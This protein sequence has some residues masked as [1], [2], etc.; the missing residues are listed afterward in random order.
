[1]INK[2][3]EKALNEQFNKELFASHLYLSMSSYFLDKDLDGFANYFRIQ[4]DEEK[5]HAMKFF[6]YIH[7][8]DGKIEMQDVKAPETNF[9]SIQQVF[10]VTLE[11]EQFVTKCIF[12]LVEQSL[13]EKDYATHTFLQWF[14]TEQVE[15]EAQVK[16]ILQKIKMIK[17]NT[18]ALYLLN[19]ELGKR[20]LGEGA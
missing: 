15:E 1:M 4:S 7:E 17:D 5:M 3:I 9:E 20:T 12:D 18:S 10:E 13:V 16:N 11:H 8:V 6:D 19:E 2:K 14:V